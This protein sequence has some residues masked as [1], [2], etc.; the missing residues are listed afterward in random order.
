LLARFVATIAVFA[1]GQAA[2]ERYGKMVEGKGF[3]CCHALDRM[4]AAHAINLDA[5]L[6]TNNSADFAEIDGLRLE[7]WV[8]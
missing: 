7:N 3:S 8:A 1:D 5:T 2:T 4:I 6:V